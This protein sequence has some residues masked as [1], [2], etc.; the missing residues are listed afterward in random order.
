VILKKF[1]KV[2]D[3]PAQY[4]VIF[5]IRSTQKRDPSKGCYFHIDNAVSVGTVGVK[6]G[7]ESSDWTFFAATENHKNLE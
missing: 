1:S 4:C 2:Y 5:V 3:I 6:C 7:D